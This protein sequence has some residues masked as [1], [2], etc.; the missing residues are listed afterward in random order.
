M[1]L[2]DE[3]YTDEEEHLPVMDQLSL[4]ENNSQ[5]D[6]LSPETREGERR[7]QGKD[8]NRVLNTSI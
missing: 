6:Q 7:S 8:Y 2:A 3:G 5:I 4:A 1:M